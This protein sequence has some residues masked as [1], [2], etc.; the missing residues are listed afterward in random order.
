MKAL[1]GMVCIR[2]LWN[3]AIYSKDGKGSSAPDL[4]EQW[5]LHF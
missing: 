3:L 2:G 5:T 1:V 4:P